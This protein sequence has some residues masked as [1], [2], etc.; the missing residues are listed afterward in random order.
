[1]RSLQDY[2]EIYRQVAQSLGYSGDSVELLIQ[3]LANATYIEEV[4]N[5]SYMNEASLDKAVLMN[6]KIQK[7]MDLM[8]SVYRGNCPRVI[9][10]FHPN[11]YLSWKPYDEIASSS[12]FKVFYLGYIDADLDSI[13]MAGQ[14]EFKKL[15]ES[16][17]SFVKY[18]QT[19]I[20]PEEDKEGNQKIVT[21]V[22]F[23]SSEPGI[24]VSGNVAADNQFYI[25][26]PAQENLS[27]DV[28]VEVSKAGES[29]GSKRYPVSRCLRDH[30]IGTIKEDE[31][32][33]VPTFFDLT[34]TNLGSRMYF[35]DIGELEANDEITA[36]YF[37]MTTRDQFQTN[38]LKKL[39]I[40]GTSAVTDEEDK[41]KSALSNTDWR[42]APGIYILPESP[43]ESLTSIHYNANRDRYINTVFRSNT[44]IAKL[45]VDFKPSQVQDATIRVDSE[46]NVILYYIP[47]RGSDLLTASDIERFNSL[48]KAY[49]ISQTIEI[50]PGNK[51]EVLVT[52]DV[53]L[54]QSDSDLVT[55]VSDILKNYEYKFSDDILAILR[56]EDSSGNER[57]RSELWKKIVSVLSKL[58]SVEYVDDVQFTLLSGSIDEPE[59]GA[60]D[61]YKGIT[62]YTITTQINSSVS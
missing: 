44:D 3:L 53:S 22:G 25:S 19:Y 36:T 29:G 16:F 20:V 7:C 8:Y 9:I 1:M 15:S 39:S 23:I 58:P 55:N 59:E 32:A 26:N 4:E 10:Q 35:H 17:Q 5:I 54:Y 13:I 41:L 57:K 6:S 61:Q 12:N 50:R 38:E 48:M 11:R 14:E 49:Y 24:V 47:K 51:V 31:S 21:I 34:T 40:R 27:N 28:F 30:I 46:G 62:Y 42:Y 52:V 2:R 33:P 18:E 56:S 60:E 37:R 43:T 45:L